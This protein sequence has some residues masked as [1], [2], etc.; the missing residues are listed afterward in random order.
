MGFNISIAHILVYPNLG[1]TTF[2][3]GVLNYLRNPGKP[4]VHLRKTRETSWS[5]MIV[6]LRLLMEEA[7]T[8]VHI[9]GPG[10]SLG[11]LGISS[12]GW[13]KLSG[14][15]ARPRRDYFISVRACL[16]L[17]VY[18]YVYIYI[19]IMYILIITTLQIKEGFWPLAPA[20]MVPTQ[21]VQVPK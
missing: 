7:R 9:A 20:L 16:S 13:A 21:M 17:C 12:P 11:H 3:S 6:F 2:Y 5:V 15:T 10:G 8:E 19:Y 4:R 14:T 18:I 1:P